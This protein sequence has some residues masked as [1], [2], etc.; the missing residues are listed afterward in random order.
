V[1]G[2]LS[3]F[4]REVGPWLYALALVVLMAAVATAYLGQTTFVAGQMQEMED[5]ERKLRETRW[6][7]NDLLLE[8][9]RH[10]SMSRIEEE[11]MALGLEPAEQYQYIEVTVEE[12]AQLPDGDVA[13]R[14]LGLITLSQNL[15]DWLRQLVEQFVIWAGGPVT[16]AENASSP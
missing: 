2:T 12:P 10:Q 4:S 9:A 16:R 5:L 7:N 3:R 15:P 13:R 11:A 1:R 6:S 14:S 8:I